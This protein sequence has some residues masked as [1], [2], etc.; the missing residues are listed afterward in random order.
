MCR[1]VQVRPADVF[2]QLLAELEATYAESDAA[3]LRRDGA[4]RSLAEIAA[5]A[6][7]PEQLTWSQRLKNC[8]ST[9]DLQ[10]LRDSAI[11]AMASEDWDEKKI[12]QWENACQ[13]KFNKLTDI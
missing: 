3:L 9:E 10:T 6:A 2:A 4:E 13:A 7:K 1:V 12:D 8:E 5:A 11:A